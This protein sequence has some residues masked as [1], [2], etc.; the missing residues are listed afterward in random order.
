MAI[1][2]KSYRVTRHDLDSGYVCYRVKDL[3]FQYSFDQDEIHNYKKLE[4]G[5]EALRYLHALIE[6][7]NLYPELL[8]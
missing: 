6:I 5:K 7:L 1:T 3:F 4:Y 2:H 8:V